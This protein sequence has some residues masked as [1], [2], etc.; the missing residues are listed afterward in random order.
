MNPDANGQKLEGHQ[1]MGSKSENTFRGSPLVACRAK[2]TE[3]APINVGGYYSQNGD[4]RQSFNFF[5]ASATRA[6]FWIVL[7]HKASRFKN[8]GGD[9]A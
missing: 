9:L 7:F 6:R 1:P 3:S 2:I 8:S 5:G 4:Y